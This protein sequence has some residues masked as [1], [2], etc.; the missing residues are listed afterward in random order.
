MKQSN[1]L[2]PVMACC[3]IMSGGCGSPSGKSGLAEYENATKNAT[4]IPCC[5]YLRA[6]QFRRGLRRA[7]HLFGSV[8][9]MSVNGAVCAATEY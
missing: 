3:L 7:L 6:P 5:L 4:L 9:V 8:F 1:I 2:V